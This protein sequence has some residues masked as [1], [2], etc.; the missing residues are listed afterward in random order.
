M[1][2]VV[3]ALTLALAASLLMAATA[4]AAPVKIGLMCPLTGKWASEG[5]DMRNI[6]T[7]LADE[8]NKAGGINGN[9][10]DLVVEDDGGDPRT[11]ALAAQKL[12][13]SGVIAAIGTYG[14]AV[15]EASQSIY[16]EAGVVQIATGS[17]A[18]R[19][20][21]KGLK[22]FLRTAPRDDEQGMV[23]AKLIKAK[24]Y[25]AVA[26]LHDN[27]S[28]AKGLAD[29]TKALLDKAGTKIVFYDALT[30]GERD[31]TA[32]LTKLKAANPDIIFC[33]GYYPEVGMLLRQKMEMKW[34]VPM[35]GGDAANHVD[36]V[37]ISGKEAAKGYFFLSP[38]GPQD[39]DAPAAKAM[40]TAYKAKYNGVPG[41]VWS[42]LAGDA[43]NVIVE[44]V[45]ATGKADSGAVADYLKTKLK[46]Y[47]GFT[48]QISFNEK[49]DRVG[50][51]YRVY[52]VNANGE[53]ILQ[54]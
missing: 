51:L 15:T 38:P 52:E 43:F 6:V 54:P 39:L 46:N 28:Y 4:F 23:A 24:G 31:Y 10:I 17:T 44:A 2:H 29:E 45:K 8:L 13:T 42:V 27:S 20:T 33:T 40:L 34:N 35:M 12:T 49:G 22:R 3:K 14:S 41:S 37:K 32:I 5:Q 1:K 7:L 18:V 19:L 47:P 48:G 26:L 9:K 11:A 25:K 36:L 21:E 53:F 16:D 50:D 30:P